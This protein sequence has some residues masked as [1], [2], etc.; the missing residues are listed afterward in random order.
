MIFGDEDLYL[1]F[2]A[3]FMDRRFEVPSARNGKGWHVAVDTSK[4]SPHDIN[5]PGEEK[6]LKPQDRCVLTA[7]S[8]VILVAK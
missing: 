5:L 6:V 8:L 3:D 2:H 4:R 7:R 1:M